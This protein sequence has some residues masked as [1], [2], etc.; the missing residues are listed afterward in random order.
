MIIRSVQSASSEPRPQIEFVSASNPLLK[1][2]TFGSS[3]A[4]DLWDSIVYIT[5]GDTNGRFD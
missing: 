3:C 4:E 2:Q 1:H 5:Q